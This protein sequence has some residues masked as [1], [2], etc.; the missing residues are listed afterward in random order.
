MNTGP[1]IRCFIAIEP[2]D[3][4]RAD[5]LDAA[6]QIDA[7]HMRRTPADNLHLTVK[8][9]GDVLPDEIERLVPLLADALKDASVCDLTSTGFV[10]IPNERR[11]R[12]VAMG[13][14]RPDEIAGLYELVEM[15]SEDAGLPREGRAFRPHVTLGRFNTRRRP[16]RDFRLPAAQPDPVTLPVR[17]LVVKQSI[18]E[19]SG[20]VYADLARLPIPLTNP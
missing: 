8:F 16:P 18:L 17:E 10:A 6:R 19:A 7:P 2:D 9:L 1:T 13:F 20:A 3:A 5:L 14:D 15:A 4:A 11:P 12:V